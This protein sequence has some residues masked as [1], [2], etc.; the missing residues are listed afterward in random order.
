MTTYR[1]VL[2][3]LL[4]VDT[5][6]PYGTMPASGPLLGGLGGVLPPM[7]DTGTRPDW[8]GNDVASYDPYSQQ[9]NWWQD[10]GTPLLQE[11]YGYNSNLRPQQFAAQQALSRAPSLFGSP[12]LR[13]PWQFQPDAILDPSQVVFPPG[14]TLNGR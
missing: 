7:L 2:R 13:A 1:D 11:M 9:W 12:L 6:D 10:N 4:Q 3:Q 8:V 5:P 14:L